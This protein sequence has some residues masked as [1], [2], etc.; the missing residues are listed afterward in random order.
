LL[1]SVSPS[2]YI[3]FTSLYAFDF[4]G[5]V[6]SVYTSTTVA[7]NPDELSSVGPPVPYG[8]RVNIDTYSPVSNGVTGALT[9]ETSTQVFYTGGPPAV[10]NYADLGQNCSTISGYTFV[11]GNPS[12]AGFVSKFASNIG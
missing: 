4:C 11:P 7:F 9:T 10:I 2:V 3:G 1:P 5:K 12:Q 8:S 6:G